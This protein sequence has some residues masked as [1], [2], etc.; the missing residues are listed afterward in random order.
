MY[1][2][3][4]VNVRLYVYTD[5]KSAW[6]CTACWYMEVCLCELAVFIFVPE[7]IVQ[8]LF[9]CFLTNPSVAVD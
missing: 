6:T 1:V 8:Y 5:R 2:T 7:N 4:G 9:F 3:G